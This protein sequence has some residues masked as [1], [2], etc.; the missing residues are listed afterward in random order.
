[1]GGDG[2]QGGRDVGGGGEEYTSY[3][4]GTIYIEWNSFLCSRLK[5]R[6]AMRRQERDRRAVEARRKKIKPNA[7]TMQEKMLGTHEKAPA[8]CGGRDLLGK[9]TEEKEPITKEAGLA[10]EGG[11]ATKKADE[12]REPRRGRSGEGSL[13]L[14]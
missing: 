1:V 7:K 11:G 4:G 5:A 8:W 3:G 2:H 6:S 9:L 14:K 10:R 12:G 13:S